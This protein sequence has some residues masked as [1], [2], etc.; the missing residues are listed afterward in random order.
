MAMETLEKTK[1]DNATNNFKKLKNSN[2]QKFERIDTWLEKESNIYLQE[3]R[4]HKEKIYHRFKRGTIIKAD[5]GINP[6]SELCHTHFAIVVNKDDNVKKDTLIVI[7]LTSKPGV[8]R[9]P[10]NTLIVEEILK[11][12]KKRLKNP[13]LTTEDA[14]GIFELLNTYK[15]YKN[16]SYAIISQITT[17]SKSRII[18]S[19]NKF[20]IINK[21]RCSDKIL[22]QLDEAILKNI[23]GIKLLR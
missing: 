3:V 17:I 5:F 14:K 22:E 15:K 18:Y 9:L 2:N 8:G 1:I 21:S 23:T 12:I 7:P 20:D 6:G 4:T 10:L 19:K 13:N 16:F 11:S